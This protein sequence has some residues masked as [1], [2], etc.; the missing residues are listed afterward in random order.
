MVDF[1]LP[2]INDDDPGDEETTPVDDEA[3]TIDNEGNE[4]VAHKDDDNDEDPNI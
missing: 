4:G 1:N 2:A 3:A